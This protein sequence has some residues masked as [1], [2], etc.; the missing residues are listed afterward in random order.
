M[1]PLLARIVVRVGQ[2]ERVARFMQRV[3]GAA[4]HPGEERVRDVRDQ[5]ADRERAAHLQAPRDT[6]HAVPERV[7]G[8]PH[9]FDGL[10]AHHPG[11]PL[12][13]GARRRRGV[14]PGEPR[15]VLQVR[16]QVR[17]RHGTG[18]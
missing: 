18:V 5:H 3:L 4:H 14:D 11:R 13:E 9:P 8:V 17:G 7:G 2:D 16:W 12:V 15:D 6:V 10:G 1:A